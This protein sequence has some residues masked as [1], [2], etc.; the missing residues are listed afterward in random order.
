MRILNRMGMNKDLV[1]LSFVF[2]FSMSGA[3]VLYYG[4]E[5]GMEGGHDPDCRRCMIWNEEEQD[6]A[7]WLSLKD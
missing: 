2:L 3:P 1:K 5:V 6:L 4:T 7:L